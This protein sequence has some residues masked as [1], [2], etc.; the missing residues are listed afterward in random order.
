M[1]PSPAAQS[2]LINGHKHC[3]FGRGTTLVLATPGW[4]T[5]GLQEI[6]AFEVQDEASVTSRR[7]FSVT[8]LVGGRVAAA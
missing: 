2:F 4:E 5:C 3:V 6:R 1:F 7:I 8:R